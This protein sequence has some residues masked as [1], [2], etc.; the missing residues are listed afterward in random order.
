MALRLRIAA[1]AAGGELS[2]S[3][4]GASCA[5][6]GAGGCAALT[7]LRSASN[8]LLVVPN[9]RPVCAARASRAA[10]LGFGSAANAASSTARCSGAMRLR[11]AAVPAACAR[12]EEGAPRSGGA[13]R[14]RQVGG[15]LAAYETRAK[16]KRAGGGPR[17][18]T[19]AGDGSAGGGDSSPASAAAAIA[20]SG[21]GAAGEP[22]HVPSSIASAAFCGD[23][24]AAAGGAGAGAASAPDATGLSTA[25]AGSL[26]KK[27]SSL[28]LIC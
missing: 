4:A 1:G 22:V 24:A 17:A 8:Q 3:A 6:S 7:R 23:A 20:A 27:A 19:G 12:G 14:A 11:F 28:A 13:A 5:P 2:P 9:S 16:Q 26:G 25:A 15:K 18:R 10:T 21:A